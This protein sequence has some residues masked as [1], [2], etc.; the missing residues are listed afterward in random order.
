MTWTNTLHAHLDVL[1]AYE[2]GLKDT[3]EDTQEPRQPHRHPTT[4][5]THDKA[6]G[7]EPI[8]IKIDYNT[9]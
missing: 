5:A 3:D 9:R 4:P 2:A 7:K 6:K 8:E 1:S